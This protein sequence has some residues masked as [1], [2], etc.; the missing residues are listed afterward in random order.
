[1]STNVDQV[2]NGFV[3]KRT[4]TKMKPYFFYETQDLLNPALFFGDGSLASQGSIWIRW[5]LYTFS[6]TAVL[7]NLAEKRPSPI[8]EATARE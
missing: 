3:R 6:S 5:E 1:M 8:P 2:Q 4:E 7:E